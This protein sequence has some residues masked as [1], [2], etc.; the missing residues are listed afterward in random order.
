MEND[1]GSDASACLNWRAGLTAKSTMILLACS[2]N[3]PPRFL[4]TPAKW[5]STK[6][7]SAN[8]LHRLPRDHNHGVKTPLGA[9]HAPLSL[10]EGH[11]GALR[12]KIGQIAMPEARRAEALCRERSARQ[13]ENPH[14]S[15][16][17]NQLDRRL[18]ALLAN[19]LASADRN[20]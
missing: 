1:Y 2:F 12:S 15:T 10:G 7:A 6:H 8:A 16:V 13:P 5:T 18:T 3:W 9:T 17:L 4:N 20:S 14:F 19:L 11:A